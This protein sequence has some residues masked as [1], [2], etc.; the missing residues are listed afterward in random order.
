MDVYTRIILKRILICELVWI[1]VTQNKILWWDLMNTLMKLT[2]SINFLKFLD[3]LRHY[4]R[5]NKDS[6]IT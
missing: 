5:I 6:R 1:R 4:K 3:Q 2:S